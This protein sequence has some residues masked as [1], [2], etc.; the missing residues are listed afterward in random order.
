MY[1][2][3]IGDRTGTA[4]KLCD[5][6]LAERSGELSGFASK[7]LFYWVMTNNPLEVFRKF[8]GAVRAIF[9]F[10]SPFWLLILDVTIKGA[11]A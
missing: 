10:V 6:D 7:P 3:L 1:A 11:L 8:F 5:K 9:G 4:K 2:P